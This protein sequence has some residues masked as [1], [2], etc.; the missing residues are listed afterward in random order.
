V[1]ERGQCPCQISTLNAIVALLIVRVPM[2]HLLLL[3]VFAL[4]MGS[5][6]HADCGAD[7]N[8]FMVSAAKDMAKTRDKAGYCE[9]GSSTKAL[10]YGAS[11]ETIPQLKTEFCAK[12]LKPNGIS[13]NGA[14]FE[15]LLEALAAYVGKNPIQLAD[16]PPLATWNST[17]LRHLRAHIF[18]Y[19]PRHMPP[20]STA[21]SKQAPGA[22]FNKASN[23]EDFSSELRARIRDYESKSI[24]Q[25]LTRFGLAEAVAMKDLRPGDIVTFNRDVAKVIGGTA[26][27]Q[28]DGSQ[29]SAVFLGWVGAAQS[30][31]ADYGSARGFRYVSSQTNDNGAGFG[32]KWAYFKGFCP[33]DPKNSVGP[34]DKKHCPDQRKRDD[35]K[36]GPSYPPQSA[37]QKSDCCVVR[38]DGG[39]IDEGLKGGR[40]RPPSMWKAG[41]EGKAPK[42][43]SDLDALVA[44]AKAERQAWFT[45][46][47]QVAARGAA[48]KG[49]TPY[50]GQPGLETDEGLEP[51][52]IAEEAAELSPGEQFALDE[53][54]ADEKVLIDSPKK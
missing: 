29:H 3:L 7:F 25:G 33:Q 16:L 10:D 14:V 22:T 18:L 8:C 1:F 17:S 5:S 44:E 37:R 28:P 50:G 15:I 2:K 46:R 13:C 53:Q 23:L 49:T 38:K 26:T 20:F 36:D 11:K 35:G 39:L 47:M 40:L 51:L 34:D 42:L 31:V 6:A 27:N 19:E 43:S 12:K 32:E 54:P 4:G 24:S 52:Q 30:D 48:N 21:T 45:A 9:R 41:F